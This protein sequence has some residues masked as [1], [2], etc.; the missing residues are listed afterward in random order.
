MQVFSMLLHCVERLCCYVFVI[1]ANKKNE[2]HRG[3]LRYPYSCFGEDYFFSQQAFSHSAALGQTFSQESAFSQVAQ[4][5][6]QESAAQHVSALQQ[7]S[8]T[9]HVSA[10]SHTTS[11]HFFL[12]LQHELM[13]RAATA[14]ITNNT[15]FIFLV[16]FYCLT[17]NS[18]S[19]QNY[20][21]FLILCCKMPI[22]LEKM[23]NF[24][25]YD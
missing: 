10:C 5:M 21:H 23:R 15:F 9:Q 6:W 2:V 14:T 12:L 4:S 1:V 11:L 8:T 18:K 16:L 19:A 13:V 3:A 20:K 24:V 7:E 22:I 25:R 17:I